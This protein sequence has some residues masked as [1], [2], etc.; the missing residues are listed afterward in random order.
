MTY[1]A[2]PSAILQTIDLRQFSTW[3]AAQA[4]VPMGSAVRTHLSLHIHHWLG[5]CENSS[6][7]SI[8]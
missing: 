5:I 7:D 6:R 8:P 1:Y 3:T 4:W 2:Q